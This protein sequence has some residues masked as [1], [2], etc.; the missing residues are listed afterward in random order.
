MDSQCKYACIARG[1][2]SIYLRIPVSEAY[3]EKIWDHASG[4]LIV[5]EAGGIVTDVY[6]NK[7][8][9]THGRTL[10]LNKG[11]IACHLDIHSKVLKAAL[12]VLKK[13]SLL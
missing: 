5:C 9:F 7:L 13:S 3:K 10:K 1:D 2:A 4:A 8:D 11:I 12:S 6:G